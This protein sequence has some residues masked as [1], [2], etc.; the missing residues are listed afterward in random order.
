MQAQ[1]RCLCNAELHLQGLLV[2]GML[3]R[4]VPMPLNSTPFQ[5]EVH[6]AG[7]SEGDPKDLQGNPCKV[8][9]G[10][11]MTLRSSAAVR[12]THQDAVSE[13]YL[14]ARGVSPE[15]MITKTCCPC[16]LQDH[17]TGIHMRP[18]TVT[19]DVQNVRH[20]HVLQDLE[21]GELHTQGVVAGTGSLIGEMAVACPRADHIMGPSSWL[22]KRMFSRVA[23]PP[24]HTCSCSGSVLRCLHCLTF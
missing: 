18:M 7:G 12:P 1:P 14:L 16:Q 5:P 21:E 2:A 20:L 8:T 23:I 22:T 11:H 9:Q 3:L 6:Y 19:W 17:L 24:E 15:T 4:L 10:H 13:V